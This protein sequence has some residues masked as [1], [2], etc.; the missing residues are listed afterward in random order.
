MD[1]EHDRLPR[2][3]PRYESL[4]EAKGYCDIFANGGLEESTNAV[5]LS[6]FPTPPPVAPSFPTSPGTDRPASP[7]IENLPLFGDITILE[8]QSFSSASYRSV[9]WPSI[10]STSSSSPARWRQSAKP[11]SSSSIS[12]TT[13]PSLQ[14]VLIHTPKS[15][16]KKIH[17]SIPPV[18]IYRS[19]YVFF[20]DI[21]AKIAKW[22]IDQN[23]NI[24][25]QFCIASRENSCCI[26]TSV[27]RLSNSFYRFFFETQ[28]SSGILQVL[29][30]RELEEVLEATQA[31]EF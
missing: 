10:S 5:I 9:P 27:E 25:R 11:S 30:L 28:R 26:V 12:S 8:R 18:L 20:S 29:F 7:H 4:A 1:R 16:A 24:S 22:Y 21:D 15:S 2:P 3:R 31:A 14:E 23:A 13:S 6:S 19:C 17:F